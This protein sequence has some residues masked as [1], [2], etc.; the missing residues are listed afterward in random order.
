MQYYKVNMKIASE[1]PQQ[2]TLFIKV[3]IKSKDM[4]LVQPRICFLTCTK[5]V[6]VFLVLKQA[7]H[8]CFLRTMMMQPTMKA[9]HT[10]FFFLSS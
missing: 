5:K 1:D 8:T 7:M 2:H 9:S 3:H 4:F 6:D 10:S